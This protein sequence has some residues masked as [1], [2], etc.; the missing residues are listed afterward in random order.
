MTLSQNTNT[1]VSKNMSGPHNE[2]LIT[3]SKRYGTPPSRIHKNIKLP[4]RRINNKKLHPR[5]IKVKFT[6]QTH[7]SRYKVGA[8]KY[9]IEMNDNK[10]KT[11]SGTSRISRSASRKSINEQENKEDTAAQ[12]KKKTEKSITTIVVAT[13][14]TVRVQPNNNLK[15]SLM[16]IASAKMNLDNNQDEDLLLNESTEKMALPVQSVSAP[17]LLLPTNTTMAY[18]TNG[19]LQQ[20][21]FY[22]AQQRGQLNELDKSSTVALLKLRTK[23][24][25]F[26]I[27]KFIDENDLSFSNDPNSICRQL[28]AMLNIKEERVEQWW[29]DQRKDVLKSFY[30]HRNNVIKS[31]GQNFKGMTLC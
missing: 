11:N 15:H 8:T 14:K 26:Q 28:A 29:S 13:K 6:N 12:K 23:D 18:G 9:M 30:I 19:L 27:N 17:A 24:L 21:D 2:S 25:L 3:Y 7:Q 5:G 1:Y 20:E 22:Q 31:I 4:P 16:G 10:R